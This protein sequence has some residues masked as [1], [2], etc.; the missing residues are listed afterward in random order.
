MKEADMVHNIVLYFTEVINRQAT[1]HEKLSEYL[2]QAEILLHVSACCEGFADLGEEVINNYTQT[3]GDVVHRAVELN[4]KLTEE[5]ASIRGSNTREELFKRE[6]KQEDTKTS[7]TSNGPVLVLDSTELKKLSEIIEQ[8]FF[9]YVVSAH[10][11]NTNTAYRN[12]FSNAICTAVG[13][14][15]TAVITSEKFGNMSSYSVLYQNYWSIF[16]QYS[17]CSNG[18]LRYTTFYTGVIALSL[19]EMINA[20]VTSFRLIGYSA[21][22]NDFRNA[23]ITILGAWDSG[24]KETNRL[25]SKLTLC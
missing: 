8:Q 24:D 13:L 14:G 3:V 6:F 12:E 25:L 16:L 21:Y 15:Y 2:Q 18:V 22:F 9:S 20:A 5:L 19:A 23:L 11:K 17:A 10:T 1:E 4:D 7:S